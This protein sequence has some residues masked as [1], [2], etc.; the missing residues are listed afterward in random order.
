M[1]KKSVKTVLRSAGVRRE[2]IAAARMVMERATLASIPR[3]TAPKQ[4]GRILA[5][6]SVAQ[7]RTGVNDVSLQR[8]E[9]QL[10]MAIDL[11]FEFVSALQIAHTGGAANQLAITVDDAWTSAAEH[12]APILRRRGIPWTLFVVSGWSDHTESW[13]RKD[14][15]GWD[16]LRALMGGDLE[17]GSHSVTHP[18]FAKLTSAQAKMEL[19]TSRDRIAEKLGIVP[20]SFAIPYGQSANWNADVHKLAQDA[21]YDTIYSQAETTAFPGTVRRAFVTKFDNRYIFKALL[22]GSFDRWEEWV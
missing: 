4:T 2:Q 22:N 13:T 5:Y 19:E 12:I 9:R 17:L 1:L 15:L 18:D 10:D 20:K 6:H 7:P 11:G 3:T 16:A 8:F 21:G 14:V